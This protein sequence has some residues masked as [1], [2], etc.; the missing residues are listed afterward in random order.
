MKR[1]KKLVALASIVA[2]MS[3]SHIVPVFASE[4][5]KLY[6]VS[7][8][9]LDTVW[10]WDLDQ[11]I[12]SYLPST[13]RDN[14]AMFEKYENYVFN[15]EGAFRYAL[16]KEYY[17]ELYN[18]LKKYIDEGRWYPT[19]SV[20]E[21][22]DVN[23]VAPE[24]MM[25]NILY[26]N[27]FFEEEF[28][29][30]SSDLFL[31]DCFG[32]SYALPTIATHMGLTS[33]SSSKLVWRP[34]NYL[35]FDLGMW[36][37]VDGSSIMAS[38]NPDPYTSSFGD[39][40]YNSKSYAQSINDMY[41]G[42]EEDETG[43]KMKYYGVGD[44]G[45]APR[46]SDIK[47]VNDAV[48]KNDAS[49]SKVEVIS[50][51]A[52][53]IADEMTEEE[54]AKLKEYNGELQ[55]KYHGTGS[56]TASS[57]S[58]RLNR[59][60][61]LLA[62]ATERSAVAASWL[63]TTKYDSE[64]IKEAWLRVLSNTHHDNLT[65]T[66]IQRV[67][68]EAINDYFVSLN[69][70]ASVYKDSIGG[71]ASKLD[72][73][74][75]SGI[76]LVVSN[77]VSQKSQGIVESTVE[78]EKAPKYIKVYD[79]NGKEVPSQI[80]SVNGNKVKI[81]FLA[82]VEANGYKV[83]N[84]K[85]SD[86]PC[87]LETGLSLTKSSLENNRYKVA[88]NENGDI[89]SIYDKGFNKEMLSKPMT[90]GDFKNKDKNYDIWEID[91]DDINKGPESVVSGDAKISIIENGPARISLEIERS[92]NGSKYTQLVSLDAGEEANRVDIENKVMWAETSSFLKAEFPL[93]VEN[94][95]A[96]Y[97]LGI[98]TIER[99][100]NTEYSFE[101]PAQQ[102]ADI[103]NKE[104]DY[105][106]TIMNDSKYG[107]DKPSDNTLRLTLMH[108]AYD[109]RATAS[110][111]DT[112]DF[113]ENRF[114]FSIMGHGS[115]WR[116]G[117]SQYEAAKLNQPM[118][119]FQTVSH[120]GELGSDFSFAN[121]DTNQVMIKA[122]K[123]A[124]KT[125]EIIVRVN[126][127]FGREAKNVQL[128]MGDG[129]ASVRA[130][131][132]SEEEIT[133][134]TARIVDGKLVF[135]ITSYAPKTFAITLNDTK[136]ASKD[137]KQFV[138]LDNLY[139][140]DIYS[141]DNNKGDGDFSNGYTIP[142]ELLP[143][144][145]IVT[146]GG[147]DFKL[148]SAEDGQNNA[149]KANGQ[150][151]K[152]PK[153]TKKL[154]MLASGTTNDKSV[155][156]KVGDVDKNI[157]LQNFTEMIGGWDQYGLGNYYGVKESDIGFVSSHYHSPRSGD[158]LYDKI[159]LFKYEID[160]PEGVTNITLPKDDS[161]VIAS[162]TSEADGEYSSK[163]A[164]DLYDKREDNIEYTLTVKDGSGSGK[165]H[166]G[167]G[168][169]LKYTGSET[170]EIV[171]VGENGESYEG[172]DIRINMPAKTLSLVPVPKENIDNYNA[173][174]TNKKSLLDKILKGESGKKE[175]LKEMIDTANYLLEVSTEGSYKG[176]YPT[177]SKEDLNSSIE[178]TM[179][180]YKS[181]IST[182]EEI[183]TAKTLL[184]EAINKF[185]TKVIT[186]GEE[187]PEDIIVSKVRNL[188]LEEIT[189]N[190]ATVSWLEP[191]S[192]AGLV[193]YVVYKDGK[194]L[195]KVPVG[196]TNYIVEGLKSNTIYGIKITAKYSNGEESKPISLNIRT[197][198]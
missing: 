101:V 95:N 111:H 128:T 86:K 132:G 121:L 112:M 4:K 39:N 179:D 27:S 196:T 6:A 104:K 177:G 92:N 190:S 85:E 96:T 9:H 45:G 43:R 136:S 46:S 24:T 169:S 109:Q 178:K 33:F 108:T 148:G 140:A 70:F 49:N 143:K 93:T 164:S 142:A 103:T 38:V 120:E 195:T 135:D 159:Y 26:G 13:L 37:G 8:A 22:G 10:N 158:K 31:P 62:D 116:D 113:G 99:G 176:N 175:G 149:I 145:N 65:G 29:K 130:V 154:Y 182:Q 89:S 137:G 19:G 71:V 67:Y 194:E 11:T 59:K 74:V 21:N 41:N 189:N 80:S 42:L 165:Y 107:W 106:I 61:E 17:P 12:K 193:E 20:W 153:G 139:N 14:F 72:T 51:Y 91:F 157:N 58:K 127:N 150:V 191:I 34:D 35:P 78:F 87:K 183:N 141:F 144:D 171:W 77:S 147:V 129:I 170:G 185:K 55:M 168:V 5:P 79:S 52:G 123:K 76:P 90:L 1:V 23:V 124:E 30:K 66:G 172:R 122:I 105:G 198:K 102:W 16:A 134:D 133:D 48:N 187:I 115:D 2:F 98:G 161:L 167:N 18:E 97:D 75:E 73:Q 69:Q 180:I 173:N 94:S 57:I 131:N 118:Q 110:H 15:F 50:A 114:T 53:Q 56:F 84:V 174:F 88:I 3:S 25:R 184:L 138:D 192:T 100:N 126:E 54:K 186:E 151:I 155:N 156:I 68:T 146:S 63:G 163:V 36:T 166:E 28:G 83:Y 47:N 125:D 162:M 160:I 64:N 181:E 44:V 7:N 188:K 197:T 60:N 119:V 152:P 32:F 81:L 82:D 117:N 40:I